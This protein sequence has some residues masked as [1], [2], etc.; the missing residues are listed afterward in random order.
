M[1][2]KHLK[3]VLAFTLI[4]L[5]LIIS[6]I[7]IL[8]AVA[9]PRISNSQPDTLFFSEEVYTALRYARKVAMNSQCAVAVLFSSNTITLNREK[10]CDGAGGFT[11]TV[12]E[13]LSHD[14]QYVLIIPE[15]L[16]IARTPEENFYFDSIGR[17]HSVDTNTVID[18]S[19]E[20]NNAVITLVGATGVITQ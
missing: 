1:I 18:V 3:K 13:P 17:V 8:V 14:S 4:E 10:N 12:F 20:V 5:V 11:E 7:G 9:A 6:L 15:N 16:Q 19:L 2:K